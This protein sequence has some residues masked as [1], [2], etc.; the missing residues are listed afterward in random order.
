VGRQ[1]QTVIHLVEHD[2]QLPQQEDTVEC[3]VFTTCYYQAVFELWQQKRWRCLDRDIRLTQLEKAISKITMTVEPR[4]RHYIGIVDVS[5]CLYIE[6]SLQGSQPPFLYRGRSTTRSY[7]FL[8]RNLG[9]RS[10]GHL[11]RYLDI[12]NPN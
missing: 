8:H 12:K 1:E 5:R 11:I 9:V 4:A 7:S 2:I 3:G 6:Q 10:K